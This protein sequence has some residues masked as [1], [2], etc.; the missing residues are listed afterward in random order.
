[1]P[2]VDHP[3][4]DCDIDWQRS[5]EPDVFVFCVYAIRS[6]LVCLLEGIGGIG[7]ALMRK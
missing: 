2:C 6:S 4:S 1:M 5:Q 3:D 7:G